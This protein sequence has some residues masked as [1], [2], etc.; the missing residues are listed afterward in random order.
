MA[1]PTFGQPAHLTERNLVPSASFRA[2]GHDWITAGQGTTAVVDPTVRHS[3]G[4]ALKATDRGAQMGQSTT[5]HVPAKPGEMYTA[6]AWGRLAPDLRDRGRVGI[7]S[8]QDTRFIGAVDLGEVRE[9]T[10]QRVSG[11]FPVLEGA[12]P[13][14]LRFMPATTDNAAEGAGWIADVVS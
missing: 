1:L 11:T 8:Y 5:P 4:N 2:G 9:V 7:E 3:T 13:F 10:W 12:T 6:E 14:V